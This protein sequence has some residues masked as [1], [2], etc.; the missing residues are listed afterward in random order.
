MNRALVIVTDSDASRSM[1]RTAGTVAAAHDAPLVVYGEATEQ[2]I[3][4]ATLA[5]R[6][7]EYQDVSRASNESAV[8]SV[9]RFLD[10]IQQT[11]LDSIDID[12]ETVCSVVP[13][14]NHVGSVLH[15][16]EEYDCD[17]LFVV[18]EKRSPAGKA[19][20]GDFIQSLLLN[21]EGRVTVE[22]E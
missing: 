3:S 21:F 5:S 22:L 6:Q 13:S 16:A 14:E 15:T 17:H 4:D 18:G 11:E 2:D 7:D 1:V 8:E 20:F 19:L 12:Y 10:R 9:H